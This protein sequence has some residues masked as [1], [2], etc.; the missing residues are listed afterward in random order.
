MKTLDEDSVL[1]FLN[2]NIVPEEKRGE[3][4]NP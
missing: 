4:K 3:N 1:L 2:P